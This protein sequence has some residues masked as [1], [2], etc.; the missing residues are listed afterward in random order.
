VKS[1]RPPKTSGQ[2]SIC[3]IQSV[4]SQW[5]RGHGRSVSGFL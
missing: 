2:I 4:M 5:E 1:W 3:L